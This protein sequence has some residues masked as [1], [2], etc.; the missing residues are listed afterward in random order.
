MQP[1][2]SAG[3]FD[4]TAEGGDAGSGPSGQSGGCGCK[5]AQAKDDG[6]SSTLLALGGLG[7]AGALRLRR[8]KKG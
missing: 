3:E 5:I 6:P 7:F 1:D 4:A 2:S 8:R